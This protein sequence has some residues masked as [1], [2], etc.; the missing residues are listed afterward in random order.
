MEV[1]QKTKDVLQ[2]EKNVWRTL[3]QISEQGV[4][5]TAVIIFILSVKRIEGR[6]ECQ[7]L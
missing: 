4:E 5:V 7:G 1:R 6:D 2:S 3:V